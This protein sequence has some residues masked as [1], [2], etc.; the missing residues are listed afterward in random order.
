MLSLLLVT[1]LRGLRQMMLLLL[2]VMLLMIWKGENGRVSI[3]GRLKGPDLGY[4]GPSSAAAASAAATASRRPRFVRIERKA[5]VDRVKRNRL[6][7][8]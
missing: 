4:Q 3:R 6:A 8:A 1:V 5:S 7:I 2:M